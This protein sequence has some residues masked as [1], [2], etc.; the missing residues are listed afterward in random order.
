MPKTVTF[1]HEAMKTT[2]SLRMPEGDPGHLRN[3]AR[4]CFEQVDRL[5]SQL[6]RFVEGSDVSQI[7]HMQAGDSLFISEDCHACLLQAL[8]LHQETG[9]LFDVTLGAR[10]E[11]V[12]AGKEG[13]APPVL[14]SL[15]VAPDRPLIVCDSPGREIDLGGIGKGFALD[16]LRETLIEWE[17]ESALI[18]AGASTQ[19]AHGRLI[20]PLEL[21]GDHGAV[22][23]ELR[24]EALSASG[25]GIQ[26]GHIVHP[27]GGNGERMS[28]KR[29]WLKAPTAAEADAW[30]TAVMLMTD[31][32]I[33]E[34][35]DDQPGSLYVEDAEGIRRWDTE[36]RG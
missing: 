20:W 23:I 12:K 34:L 32:Q 35:G 5:E 3:V 22:R 33:R 28:Y 4:V 11:H 9:G 18:S 7:N 30:S 6:S 1:T 31:E 17:V 13:E 21:A 14:G 10:I 25:V 27:D 2:F 8:R 19:L 36:G 24:G 15:V 29:L 26:G 16:R